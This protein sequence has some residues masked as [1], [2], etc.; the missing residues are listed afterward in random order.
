[1]KHFTLTR[2]HRSPQTLLVINERD[3][4][5]IAAARFFPGI[6]DR[7]IARQLHRALATYH[8]GRWRRDYTEATCPMQ[9]KGRL[10]QLL[11]LIFKVHDHVPSLGTVRAALARKADPAF[12]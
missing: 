5:L 2:G 4:Y 1:M 8:A 3:K 10:Q 9:H 6:S 7:E 11:W 12:R